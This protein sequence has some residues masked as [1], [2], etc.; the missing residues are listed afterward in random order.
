M[1]GASLGMSAETKRRFLLFAGARKHDAAMNELLDLAQQEQNSRS[2]SGSDIEGAPS[3]SG[4]DPEKFSFAWFE[5]DEQ[6][7]K[8]FCGLPTNAFNWL[9]SKSESEVRERL[10]TFFLY[11][12]VGP[13][14]ECMCH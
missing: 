3:S 11:F 12:L 2:S 5:D 8:Y 6:A 1:S 10:S 13:I 14:V 9:W 7:R 4:P